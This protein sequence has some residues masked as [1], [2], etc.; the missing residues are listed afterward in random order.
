[1]DT[2]RESLTKENTQFVNI[3]WL[4]C[5]AAALFVVQTI[6]YAS[7]QVPV[8]VTPSIGVNESDCGPICLS[9]T[10]YLNQIDVSFLVP[11]FTALAA[12]DHIICF[13]LC[14]F[15]PHTAKHYL[16]DVGSNPVRW[17]EYSLSASVMAVAVAV[18][19][20][21]GDVHLW[22]LVFIFHAVGMGFGQV[23]LCLYV[24]MS[25]CLYTSMSTVT[26][27]MYIFISLYLHHP[28]STIYIS[29][30][31]YVYIFYY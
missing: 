12:I 6:I 2:E 28:S 10:K 1:M 19:A 27:S 8:E 11:V 15:E 16:F 30:I 18:L 13:S 24:C 7:L 22:F 3:K 23:C 4:H 17:A 20:G 14:A 29:I 26:R 25:V 21:V 31:Y 5:A 9:S